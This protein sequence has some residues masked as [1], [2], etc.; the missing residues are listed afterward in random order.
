MGRVKMFLGLFMIAGGLYA[1]MK[2]FPPYFENYQFQDAIKEEAVRDSYAPKSVDDI[3]TTVF[4]KAQELEIPISEESIKVTHEGYQF[5]GTIT[6]H[7]AYVVH[8]DM[9]G[10]PLDLH[11]DASTEN[12][13]VF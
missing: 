2:L 10:Y 8:V 7:A 1:A 13:G 3:R 11:F 4:K 9:P 6:I 12:K 5:S